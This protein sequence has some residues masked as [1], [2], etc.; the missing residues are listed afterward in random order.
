MRAQIA[1]ESTSFS[2]WKKSPHQI[3]EDLV[4]LPT[5]QQWALCQWSQPELSALFPPAALPAAI[6]WAASSRWSG[7]GHKHSHEESK[8]CAQSHGF[9]HI[10]Q[11]ITKNIST[12]VSFCC[13]GR[14]AHGPNFYLRDTCLNVATKRNRQ[15]SQ[16]FMSYYGLK[17]GNSP[18]HL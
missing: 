15:Y 18:F 6:R 17:T 13:R 3:L 16:K 12:A 8:M 5:G 9:F 14:E 2:I 11:I 4:T 1:Q 10:H 7:C